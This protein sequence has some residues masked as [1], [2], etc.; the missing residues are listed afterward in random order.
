MENNAKMIDGVICSPSTI[1]LLLL[2][3]LQISFP[4]NS[5]HRRGTT[6]TESFQHNS[7]AVP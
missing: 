2:C 5:R 4:K 3:I 7:E 6:Q 1:V